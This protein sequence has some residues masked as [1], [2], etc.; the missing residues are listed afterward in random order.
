M[1]AQGA[2]VIEYPSHGGLRIRKHDGV[3]GEVTVHDVAVVQA[4]EPT[5]R[6]N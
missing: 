6:N 3:T 4:G 1:R 5:C 2:C